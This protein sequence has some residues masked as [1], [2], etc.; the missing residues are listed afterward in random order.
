MCMY[1]QVTTVLIIGGGCSG[2]PPHPGGAGEEGEG[3][4]G[5]GRVLR[6]PPDVAGLTPQAGQQAETHEPQEG[7]HAWRTDTHRHTHAQTHTPIHAHTYTHARTHTHTH[8]Q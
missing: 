3:H 7:P 6:D 5:A 2:G 8:T 4:G 1:V